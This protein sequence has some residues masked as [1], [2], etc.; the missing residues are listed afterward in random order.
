MFVPLGDDVDTHTLPMAGMALVGANVLIFFAMVGMAIDYSPP[1]KRA[2]GA[3]KPHGGLIAATIGFD[4]APQTREVIFHYGLTPKDLQKDRFEGLGTY[5]F[6]HGGFMHLLGNMIVLWAFVS[7]LE[8]ALGTWTF[9]TFYLLWGVLAG[10][11]H[12]AVHWGSEVPL[13]GASGAIAGV[14]GAYWVLAGAR[15]RIRTLVWIIRPHVF[16]IP[17]GLFVAFWIYTQIDG[18]TRSPHSAVGTAWYCHL[19]GFGA[20]VVTMLLLRGRT[21]RRLIN[22]R[23]GTTEF[24]EPAV[25]RD[26]SIAADAAAGTAACP[27]CG[28]EVT[29]ET[30]LA[31]NLARCPNASCG[32]LVLLERPLAASSR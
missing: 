17:A 6:V 27:Y 7:T 15:T 32:R 23:F 18:V 20:G 21:A 5:M 13:V 9:L 14:I 10:L 25:R 16:M 19:G 29:A 30:C 24:Q 11:A 4:Q 22:T 12:A 1:I 31:P 28:T 3:A 2:R 26:P 8:H